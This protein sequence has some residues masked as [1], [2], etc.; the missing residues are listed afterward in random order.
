MKIELQWYDTNYRYWKNKQID[1]QIDE[2][3]QLTN[4]RGWIAC[5]DQNNDVVQRYTEKVILDLPDSLKIDV[6][7]EVKEITNNILK[8]MNK[9]N[10]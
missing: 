4:C 3:N 9:N 10:K 2:I 5:L 8:L 1:T 7:N 6:I